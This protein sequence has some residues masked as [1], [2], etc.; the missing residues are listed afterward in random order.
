MTALAISSPIEEMLDM[1]RKRNPADL[2]KWALGWLLRRW[3]TT[4]TDDSQEAFASRIGMSQGG[5]S[6]AEKA[7]SPNLDLWCDV[8]E[9]LDKDLVVALG[10]A[11]IIVRAIQDEED[12]LGRE[13][14]SDQRQS[15]A[16]QYFSNM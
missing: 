13:L 14:S 15:I 4:Q 8:F 3:R 10:L 11:R 16:G 1:A 2:Y 6:K 7:G 9:V 5:L 12:A